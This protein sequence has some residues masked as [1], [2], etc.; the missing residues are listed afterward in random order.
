MPTRR[1]LLQALL[2]T[3][4]A[5]GLSAT[6]PFGPRLAHA[7]DPD[8]P[9]FLVVFGCFG[10]ASMMDAFMPVD[11]S[12][13]L[14]VAGRGTVLAYPT[15]QP[16]GTGDAPEG[17]RSAADSVLSKKAFRTQHTGLPHNPRSRPRAG[18]SKKR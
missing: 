6:L 7:T 13:A 11:T 1:Q 15:W 4:A 12:E 2:A 5:G 3:G 10:G 9:R 8:D 16:A 17:A 18:K 14:T